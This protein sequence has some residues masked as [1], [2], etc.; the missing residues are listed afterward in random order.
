MATPK[1]PTTKKTAKA[2]PKAG[3]KIPKKR[4]RLGLLGLVFNLGLWGAFALALLLGF[5]SLQLPDVADVTDFTRR[6]SVTLLSAEGD[7]IA[8]YGDL[9]GKTLTFQEIPKDIILAILATEDRRFFEH[10]GLDF[11]GIGRAMVSNLLAGGVVEGGSTLTQQ[12]AKNL[13]LTHERTYSRKLREVVIAYWLERHFSKEEILTLYLN[14]V[15]FGA[16]TYGIAGAAENYYNRTPAELNQREAAVLVGLLKA[17]S[18]LNPLIRPERAATR[19]D[20][21]LLNMADAGLISETDATRAAALPLRFSRGAVPPASRYF[22]DWVMD[23]LPDYIG[24]PDVDIIV[25]T[26]LSLP[27]QRLAEKVLTTT[28]NDV[29]LKSNVSQA[30]LLSLSRNGA[31]VAMVGGINYEFSQFNRVT[32]SLRQPGSAF[33]LFVAAAALEAGYTTSSEL[34]DEAVTY[35]GWTPENYDGTHRG[36]VTLLDAFRDSLNVPM[37]QL[38]KEI[39]LG[40]VLRTAREMGIASPI[41]RD[42]ASAL[43]ASELSLYELTSAYAVVAADG[44]QVRPYGIVRIKTRDGG[45]T[46]YRS[47]NR[48]ADQVLSDNTVMELREM[49][50]AVMTSGTGKAAQIGL[51]AGGKTGTSQDFKDAWFIGSTEQLTTGIWVGNDD[52][53]P[54]EKVTGGGLPARL[55]K[56]YMQGAVGVD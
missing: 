56:G 35:G 41:R 46:L 49:L 24:Y 13:F 55:W 26:T 15:Y 2:S 34:L 6:P 39:G 20:Q 10:G 4:R 36:A 45:E 40:R 42:L 8:T 29:G 51:P 18:R 54:M 3:Q 9:Y 5:Y 32:Q 25:E 14:R 38:A 11:R 44:F 33:K 7:T 53:A 27:R 37:V 22:A 12:L 50:G 16:G 43:G 52:N 17:P 31:V 28:I 47:G 19:G 23:Q 1:K 21:V 30:A 48:L